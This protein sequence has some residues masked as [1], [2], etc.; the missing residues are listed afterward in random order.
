MSYITEYVFLQIVKQ[1]DFLSKRNQLLNEQMRNLV[2][3]RKSVFTREQV[4]EM[5]FIFPSSA[6]FKNSY[7]YD[8]NLNKNRSAL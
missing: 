6:M 3:I 7:I 4:W 8:I 5:H 1:R 2:Q